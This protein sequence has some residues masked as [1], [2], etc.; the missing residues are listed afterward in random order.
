[1]ETRSR[2]LRLCSTCTPS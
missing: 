2:L 1:M